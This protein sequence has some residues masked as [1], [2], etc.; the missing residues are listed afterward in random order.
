MAWSTRHWAR[1]SAKQ[2]K[3]QTRMMRE[4][5][6]RERWALRAAPPQVS[7]VPPGWYPSQ[8]DPPG[9]VRWWDGANWTMHTHQLSG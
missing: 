2:A 6:Q 1:V 9:V 4:Q 5:A 3:K 7:T 8:M